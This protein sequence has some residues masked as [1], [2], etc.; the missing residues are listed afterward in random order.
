VIDELIELL[1]ASI[2]RNGVVMLT[3][4]HMLNLIKLAQKRTEEKQAAD[5]A[6]Q[7]EVLGDIKRWGA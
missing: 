4:A 5:E 3:N 6:Y 7:T 1:E 2:S